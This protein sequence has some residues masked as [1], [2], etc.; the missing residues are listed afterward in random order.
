MNKA[1]LFVCVLASACASSSAPSA[2]NAAGGTAAAATEVKK[3]AEPTIEIA[4]LDVNAA[5]PSTAASVPMIVRVKV[6]NRTEET[7][8]VDRIDVS[9]VGIGAYTINSTSQDFHHEVKVGHVSV[10]PVWVQAIPSTSNANEAQQRGVEESIVGQEGFVMMRAAVYV[11]TPSH[12]QHRL[13]TVQKVETSL[14]H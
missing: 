13:N 4:R 6:E 2:R 10:F 14:T 3:I 8:T 7:V 5:Q 9:T 11:T 1:W 12:P